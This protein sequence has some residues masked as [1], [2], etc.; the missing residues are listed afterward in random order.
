MIRFLIDE[1]SEK[2]LKMGGCNSTYVFGVIPC[3]TIAVLGGCLTT[4]IALE[5]VS[6]IRTAGLTFVEADS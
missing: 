6:G 4:A 3:I 2:S 1:R 5:G